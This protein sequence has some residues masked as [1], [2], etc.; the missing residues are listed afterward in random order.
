M[1]S[2]P[3]L[4]IGQIWKCRGNGRVCRLERP[5]TRDLIIGAIYNEDLTRF[6]ENE[7]VY[8]AQC[9]LEST[10]PQ[11]Y[12][13]S[14]GSITDDD[15]LKLLRTEPLPD[16]DLPVL[17][18]GQVWMCRDQSYRFTVTSVSAREEGQR[19]PVAIGKMKRHLTSLAGT[20]SFDARPTL[21]GYRNRADNRAI[22]GTDLTQLLYDPE[23]QT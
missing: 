17:K 3:A 13:L 10:T 20:Y 9:V 4:A 14:H 6:T 2:L 18:R 11:A 1:F 21:Q 8:T 5:G 16:P 12:L 22:D 15:L 7:W 23:V 19:F